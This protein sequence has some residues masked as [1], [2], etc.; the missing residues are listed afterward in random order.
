MTNEF[1]KVSVIGTGTMSQIIHLPMIKSIND[2]LKLDMIVD[3]YID[4][5]ELQKLSHRF[6]CR[7]SRNISEV[8]SDL[9]VIVTPIS[10]HFDVAKSLIANN[11]YILIEK[12]IAIT[13]QNLNDLIDLKNIGERKRIFCAH[14]RRFFKNNNIA[15]KV[16]N[17]G[18][19]G[20]IKEVKIFEGNLYGW[21]RKYYSK[22]RDQKKKNVDEG[23]LF[24]VGSHSIDSTAFMFSD[25]L[26]DVL[27]NKSIVDNIEFMSNIHICGEML[28]RDQDNPVIFSASFSNTTT[29]SNV[30]WIKGEKATLMISPKDSVKPKIRTNLNNDIIELDINLTSG[31]PF[32]LIYDNIINATKNNEKSVLDIEN[33]IFTTKI[34]ESAFKNAELGEIEWL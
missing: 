29:L 20:K 9:A 17:S 33:F 28:L 12:P 6:D 8:S 2:R 30:I 22:D 34:L 25:Y 7:W 24:D 11:K 15:K 4:E 21:D 16:I 18:L 32:Y 27:I 19:L 5:G 1:L 13:S 26:N 31:N 3:P 10:S 14:M 23:V